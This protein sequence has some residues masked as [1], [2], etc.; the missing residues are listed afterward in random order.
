MKKIVAL[1]GGVGGAKL[2]DGLARVIHGDQL[3]AV[4]N[5]GD[6]FDHLGLRICPDLDTVV[7]TLAG[8]ADPET[9]WGRKDDT[10][11][12]L[13]ALGALGGPVWFR[14]GDRDL[15]LSLERTR[16]LKQGQP[17]SAIVDHL[18]R[19]LTVPVRVLPMTDDRVP[20]MV[21]TEEGEMPFQEYF[22]AESCEPEVKGFRFDG[23]RQSRPAPGVIEALEE[24]DLVV[25][26]PSNPWVSLDPIL[27]VPGIS[28]A[29]RGKPAIGVSPI[30]GGSAI[31]GP[32]AKMF[33]ELGIEPSPLAIAEHYRGLMKQL[34]IDAQD[35]SFAPAIRSLGVEVLVTQTIM[36]SPADRSQLATEVIE[37]ALKVLPHAER[38]Q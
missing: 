17:L 7:Y 36:R 35:E 29:I 31:K 11:N 10:W 13:E 27:A 23:V 37:F 4:V 38:D 33:R 22:V 1:A 24:A 26:C 16:C 32:A 8:V 28:E 21:L 9:G 14:L 30:V 25:L 20:T 19:G 34:V 15:A 2:V 18:C 3:T 12:V 6:D 5:T